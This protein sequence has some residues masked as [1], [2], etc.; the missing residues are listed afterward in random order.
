MLNFLYFF[1]HSSGICEG[2]TDKQ[3]F[4]VSHLEQKVSLLILLTGTKKN[5]LPRRQQMDKKYPFGVPLKCKL[6][7]GSQQTFESPADSPLLVC[8]KLY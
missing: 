1:I 4:L 6:P 7:L 2:R 5:P 8:F 3:A